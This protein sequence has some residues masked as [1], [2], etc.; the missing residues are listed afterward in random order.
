MLI[1]STRLTR[2]KAVLCVLAL[3]AVLAALILLAGRAHDRRAEAQAPQLTSNEERVTYLRSMGW[4]LRPEPLETL[5]FLLP[6]ELAEPYLSYNALQEAQ[7]FDLSRC[8][9]KQVARYTYAVTNYPGRAE[10][11]QLNLYICEDQPVAGDV[12]C[13]GVEGFRETLAYPAAA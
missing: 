11:V 6:E 1:W 13:P 7:G 8:C 9:G 5:Q 10:G 12:C 3:G 2:K 4:E